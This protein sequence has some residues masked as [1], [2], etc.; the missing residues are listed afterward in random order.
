MSCFHRF[1]LSTPFSSL[2]YFEIIF[3]LPFFNVYFFLFI[4]T[5]Q[6]EIFR[7]CS[8]CKTWCLAGSGGGG[9]S[10]K[11]IKNENS[12]FTYVLPRF[13]FSLPHPACCCI[14][15]LPFS[16]LPLYEFM[17]N[18]TFI[19]RPSGMG[20]VALCWVEKLF[21][22]ADMGDPIPRFIT[23]YAG[24]STLGCMRSRKMWYQAW[25][26][27]SVTEAGRKAEF[28]RNSQLTTFKSRVS[29]IN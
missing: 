28:Q 8:S 18:Q 12:V 16:L 25:Y 4:K 1:K 7:S 17:G 29:Y 6:N 3:Y 2:P 13:P 22:L 26:Q 10:K 14:S 11:E 5:H 27:S 21:G 24:T 23:R 15:T 19:S 9:G 20:V